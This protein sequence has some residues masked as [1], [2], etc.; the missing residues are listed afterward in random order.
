MLDSLARFNDQEIPVA[1]D[2]DVSALRQFFR[3]WSEQ[4]R[5]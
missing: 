3:T 4:L 1:A 2:I 5:E